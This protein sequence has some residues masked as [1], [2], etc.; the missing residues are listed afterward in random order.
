MFDQEAGKD[1]TDLTPL[2]DF[3]Q[4]VNDSDDATFEAELA[5]HLDVDA[6]A[7]LPGVP[8]PDREP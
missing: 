1:D 5:D 4:F 8:G 2:I 3:L 7:D 6:F